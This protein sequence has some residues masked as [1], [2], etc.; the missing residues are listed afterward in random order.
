MQDDSVQLSDLQVCR[1]LGSGSFGSVFLTKHKN[2]EV[3]Y[4]LKTVPRVKIDYSKMYNHILREKNILL[5]LDHCFIIKLVKTFKDKERLYFL[6]E[7]VAGDDL[8][9][10]C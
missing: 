9:G 6:T 10:V 2:R 8:Y 5:Q 4:A 1:R 3:Y 7:D